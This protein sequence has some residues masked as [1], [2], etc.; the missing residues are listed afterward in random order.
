LPD[1][2]LG[3]GGT[4]ITSAAILTQ[5]GKDGDRELG[6]MQACWAPDSRRVAYCVTL[7]DEKGNRTGET[8]IMVTDLEGKNTTTVVAERHDPQHV[9]LSLM[10]W[11]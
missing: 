1:K 4:P 10:A 11:R 5:N 3:A 8:S 6:Y 9:V 7:L 2:F